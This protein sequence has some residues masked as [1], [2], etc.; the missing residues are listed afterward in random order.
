MDF[1]QTSVDLPG[2]SSEEVKN[3]RNYVVVHH[4]VPINSDYQILKQTLGQVRIYIQNL[5]YL[6]PFL[7]DSLISVFVVF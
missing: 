6:A 3:C 1:Q 7:L 2:W 5:S 4:G